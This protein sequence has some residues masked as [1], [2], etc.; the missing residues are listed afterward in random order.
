[1]STIYSILQ[2]LSNASIKVSKVIHW[3]PWDMLNIIRSITS[4]IFE[5][6][7]NYYCGNKFFSE[8]IQY[9]LF[10][11]IFFIYGC[12]LIG[13]VIRCIY[14]CGLIGSVIRCI[15]GC[16]LIGSV[17]RC[18][19]GCGLIGSVIRCIYGCGLIGSVIRC[20]KHWTMSSNS[21]TF[22]VIR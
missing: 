20:I 7:S 18:I 4:C 1:M 8:G 2:S 11:V 16:G 6:V 22:V 10:C 14:G 3:A 17:I 15:Y 12:G 13:S 19:Y 21:L 9:I 5:D